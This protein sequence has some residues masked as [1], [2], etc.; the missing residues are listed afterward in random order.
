MFTL[1]EIIGLM[2]MAGFI[3]IL[4]MLIIAFQD[5]DVT[6]EFVEPEKFSWNGYTQEQIDFAMNYHGIGHATFCSKEIEPYFI[7]DGEKI[8]LFTNDVKNKIK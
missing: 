3:F 5:G 7:R 4:G 8:K 1:L 6:Y 2:L